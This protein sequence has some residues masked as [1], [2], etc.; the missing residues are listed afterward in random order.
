[1]AFAL[2]GY[3]VVAPNYFR[4]DPFDQPPHPLLAQ[5][6]QI[7]ASSQ[8]HA[9][10][11]TFMTTMIN[12]NEFKYFNHLFA[13]GKLDNDIMDAA[14]RPAANIIKDAIENTATTENNTASSPS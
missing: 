4:H 6:L 7:V 11:A 14:E 9:Q 12:E 3:P 13:N 1:M 8:H 2:V 10:V 5:I